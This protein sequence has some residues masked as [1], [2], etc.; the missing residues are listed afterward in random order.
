MQKWFGDND[1]LMYSTH[2]E[3]KSVVPERFIRTLMGKICKNIT[4]NDSKSYLGYL[5]TLID[6][7]INN[8]CSTGE[9]PLN[10]DY[11]ALNEE[12]RMNPKS[13]KVKVGDRVS[14]TKYKNMFSK[15]YTENWSSEIFVI[16]SVLKTDPWT[17]I[18]KYLNR[19][20]ILGSFY[21][22]NN[23]E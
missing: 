5:N 20:K 21:E 3:D 10:A 13:P 11:C 6:E 22:K 17:D 7:C 16:D 12:I 23:I 15:V 8:Y 9:K 1:I 18:I 2:N 19:E 14:I 4:A